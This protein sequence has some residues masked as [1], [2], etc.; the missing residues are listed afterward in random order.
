MSSFLMT[1]PSLP[2]KTSKAAMT[3][4]VLGILGFFSL[5]VT[6]VPAVVC[7]HVGRAR[8]RRSGGQL[9]GK[10][11]AA[12]GLILGYAGTMGG[13]LLIVAVAWIFQFYA[14]ESGEVSASKVERFSQRAA[15]VLPAS[16]KATEYRWFFARDGQEYLKLEM[17]V[18]DLE[19]F[20]R[21]SGLEGKLGNTSHAGGFDSLFG[22]FLPAHPVSFREGQKELP[23]EEWLN[24]LVDEDDPETVAIYFCRFGT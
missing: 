17:P 22:E 16:A 9:G 10:G 13:V 12:A 23:D 5:F 2:V 4:L 21:K 19:E 11:L 7:G 8:I 20:L 6:A 3:S 1:S 14:D 24:V 15:L 18:A